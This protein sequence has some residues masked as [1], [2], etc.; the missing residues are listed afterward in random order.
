MPMPGF[1]VA[2]TRSSHSSVGS[3][4]SFYGAAAANLI[5]KRHLSD[6]R[7]I[8]GNV[9]LVPAKRKENEMAHDQAN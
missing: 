8:A 1:P 3:S 5:R 4:A 7:A 9:K 6:K 2:G